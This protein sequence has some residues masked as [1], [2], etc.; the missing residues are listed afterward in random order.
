MREF[1][2]GGHDYR[3]APLDVFVQI[4][5]GLK[6]S[7]V[8][9]RALEKTSADGLPLADILEI[10]A[11]ASGDD[12]DFVV[13]SCLVCVQRREGASWANVYNREAKRLAYTDILAA[14]TLVLVSQ[15]LEE[16]ILPFYDGLVSLV[17]GPPK[18]TPGS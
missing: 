6:I 1:R 11:S 14:D 16:Y 10:I 2:L 3:T 7:T 5:V 17:L 18:T 13:Q 4:K 15:V 9:T 8:L 12:V